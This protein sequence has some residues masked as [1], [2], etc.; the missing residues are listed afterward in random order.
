[1]ENE[2]QNAPAFDAEAIPTNAAEAEALVNH[3]TSADAPEQAPEQQVDGETTENVVEEPLHEIKYRGQLETHPLSKI[4]DFANQGRDYAEKMRDFKV[5]RE[6]FEK[7]RTGWKSQTEKEKALFDEYRQ[8]KEVAAKEPQ[9]IEQLRQAYVQRQTS[10]TAAQDPMVQKLA[11]GYEELKG[12]VSSVKEREALQE[13]A[14]EDQTLDLQVSEYQQKFPQFD[15][16]AVDDQGLNL[17]KRI[18]N[19]AIQMGLS[20][21]EHFR[22][23]AHDYLFDEHLKR[24][25]VAAKE[26]VGKEIQKA[27]KLGLGPKTHQPTMKVKKVENVSSK[28]WDDISAEAKEALGI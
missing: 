19:H 27:T 7:E 20:K 5:Q 14:Q 21:P 15:W 1:M 16:K 8:W 22:I 26:V 2:I 6:L 10:Q 9:W 23:A 4:L 18:L 17:E 28:S 12:F 11:E 13:R 3:W 25:E 24:K